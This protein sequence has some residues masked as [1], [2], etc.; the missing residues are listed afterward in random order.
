MEMKIEEVQKWIEDNLVLKGE[1]Q[2]ITGQS[3]SAFQQSVDTGRLQAFAEFGDKT[4]H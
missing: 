2:K 3:S 1:A 4:S